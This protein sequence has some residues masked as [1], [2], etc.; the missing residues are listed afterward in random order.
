MQDVGADSKTLHD[1]VAVVTGSLGLLGREHCAALAGAGAHLALVDLDGEALGRQAKELG[2]SHGVDVVATPA[3]I[4]EPQAVDAA[5]RATMARFE[6][7]DV[8][9]NNAAIDDKYEGDESAAATSR[10][11]EYC[12]ER[13][14]RVLDVNVIGAFLCCQRYGTVMARRGAGSIINVASTYGLVAPQQ[15]LYRHQGR[16]LFFKSAAYPASKAALIQLTRFI[17]AYWGAR[18]VRANALCPGGVYAGQ[19]AHFAA[20]YAA[21]TP[22]ERM[23]EPDDYRGAVVFLA[24]DASRYMTGATL[25]VDGGYTSW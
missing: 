18:S 17:A 10:F 22:L 19:P 4:T 7:V 6:R 21:R 23:A 11:E 5:V 25:V 12:P 24:S 2:E 1:R 14:R 20:A 3:D 16:Q 9:V 8:L 13:F 15:A